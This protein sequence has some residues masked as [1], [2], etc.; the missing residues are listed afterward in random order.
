M[1]MKN[2]FGQPFWEARVSQKLRGLWAWK[3]HNS[4]Q[5]RGSGADNVVPGSFSV[6]SCQLPVRNS[7]MQRY[8]GWSITWN[9]DPHEKNL[10]TPERYGFPLH[11]CDCNRYPFTQLYT[12]PRLQCHNVNFLFHTQ[13]GTVHNNPTRK[14]EGISWS[15]FSVKP[16]DMITSYF[17][18]DMEMFPPHRQGNSA[19]SGEHT[20]GSYKKS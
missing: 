3:L 13:H 8:W 5:R 18:H 12:V 14:F 19:N 15:L 16:A 10:F 4:T 9:L 20:A 2:Q 1:L 11:R 6:A 17:I 7:A